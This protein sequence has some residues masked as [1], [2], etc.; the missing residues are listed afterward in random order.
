M[1]EAW[2]CISAHGGLA[3][4]C[5]TH[6]KQVPQWPRASGLPALPARPASAPPA[7][8]YMPACVNSAAPGSAHLTPALAVHSMLHCTQ[9]P[10]PPVP[11]ATAGLST[12]ADIAT[13]EH[14]AAAAPAA[15][16]AAAAPA[17][18]SAA[19]A[20]AT[21]VPVVASP[22]HPLPAHS[23]VLLPPHTSTAPPIRHGSRRAPSL[24]PSAVTSPCTS[25][26]GQWW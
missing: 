25:W 26:A 6:V 24:I 10:Q 15:A 13:T 18:A 17:A 19:V 21:A 11:S 3:A 16:P 5:E 4:T 23:P 20:P 1:T 2:L 12:T 9:A 14:S 7:G 8:V 22:P